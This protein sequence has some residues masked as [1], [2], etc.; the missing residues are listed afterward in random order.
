M[1]IPR[2]LT[3][4]LC[5]LGPLTSFALGANING[6]A[7]YIS[8]SVPGALGTFPMSINASMIVA[9][10]YDES[11]TSRRG[12]VRD[13][14]GTITT[15]NIAGAASTQPQSINAAGD[16]TGFYFSQ[17]G[18]ASSGFLR[19]AD[20]RIIV[21]SGN[22]GA[23]ES[24]VPAAINDFDNIVGDYF[25]DGVVAF[26][27]SRTGEFTS[28]PPP[29]SVATAINATGTVVGVLAGPYAFTGFVAHPDG[30]WAAIGPA[31]SLSCG[32]QTIPDAI[33]AAGVIAGTFT[34][35]YS[36]NSS[37]PI[38][39][40]GFV[41]SPDGVFTLFQPPGQMPYFH[42]LDLE[43]PTL[44]LHLVSIDNTGDITGSYTDSGGVAHGFVRNPYGTMTSFDPP[45]GTE[46]YATS[47]ND[48]GAIAGY[49]SYK[50]GSGP[51]VG[52][53]RVP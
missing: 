30:Y 44:P 22:P 13:A 2:C 41:Q 23:Y 19:Y 51:P 46:T 28:L 38:N 20:G 6:E 37:C 3:A 16:I 49:Y 53:I 29:N 18:L 35:N 12:F 11:S 1:M 48:G 43:S 50:A 10:Y 36:F 9:G 4:A 32:D 26:S 17:P 25:H 52:F 14:E 31:A 5:V 39:T 24:V 27:R 34:A 8:F 42:D 7:T 40:G 47:I 15:F 21:L 45:E 33:N